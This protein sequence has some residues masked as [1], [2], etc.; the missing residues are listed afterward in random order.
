MDGVARW[1]AWEQIHG[2]VVCDLAFRGLQ[3]FGVTTCYAIRLDG[4]RR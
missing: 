4:Q 2:Q 1:L 3:R